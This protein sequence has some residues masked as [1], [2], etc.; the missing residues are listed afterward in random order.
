MIYTLL[1]DYN[2]QL[3]LL[4]PKNNFLQVVTQRPPLCCYGKVT[5]IGGEWGMP[6]ND[7]HSTTEKYLGP[8]NEFCEMY[9]WDP[10]I[11]LIL[12]S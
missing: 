10:N 7:C 6:N 1:A 5:S 2:A 8:N 4:W 9:C 3:V 12:G 11:G